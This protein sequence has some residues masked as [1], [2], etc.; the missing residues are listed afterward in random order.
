MGA[1]AGNGIQR[2]A[3]YNASL[4]RREVALLAGWERARRRWVTIDDIGEARQPYDFTEPAA[5]A[6]SS[7]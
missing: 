3:S 1:M 5:L 4:S 6:T 7:A 2:P